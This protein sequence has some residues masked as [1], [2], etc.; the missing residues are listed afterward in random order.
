[1][2]DLRYDPVAR[3]GFVRL[4]K[5]R[6]AGT[7]RLSINAQAEYD[8]KGRLLA[9]LVTDLDPD[10]A[11]FLRSS[12]EKTLI[13]VIRAQARPAARPRRAVGRR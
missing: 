9:V 6:I 13:N 8:Q 3:S 5:G 7:R 12:D 4:R 1:M 2:L 10:A 11:E